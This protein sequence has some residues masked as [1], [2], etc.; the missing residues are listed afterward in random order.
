MT[1][2]SGARHRM[3]TLSVD[4]RA[5]RGCSADRA[6]WRS[7]LLRREPTSHTE[8]LLSVVVACMVTILSM[9]VSTAWSD[10]RIKDITT[11]AGHRTNQLVGLGLVT[12]LNGTGGKSPITRRFAM[13]LE[14]RLGVR[15]DPQVRS[16]LDNDTTRKTDNVS[17]VVVTAD[18][19]TFAR[20]GSKID[21]L[22]SAYDDASSLQGGVLIR[23]PLTA[24][25]GE[26]YAVAAGPVSI[27]GFSF[28]GQAASI[29]KNHPTTGRIPSGGIVE[30]ET[31]TDIAADGRFQLLLQTQDFETSRRIATAINRPFPASARALDPGTVDVVVPGQF[32]GNV[33]NFLGEIG[34][35]RVTPDVPARVV[36]N[37][38]TGTVIVGENVRLSRVL[39]THSNLT[40]TT[41]E[42]PEVSQPAPFSDGVTAIVPRTDVG[43]TE[44]GMPVSEVD[45]NVTVGDL[46]SAL[47]ALGV[48][49]R[50]LSSI[51]QQLKE[52]GALHAELE[53]K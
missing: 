2:R 29:S 7:G 13:N 52:S 1:F 20:S 42:S 9:G 12:G 22:V 4:R 10:V 32:L 21:V 25:D 38:R 53:F 45:P 5:A 49:P 14:Q 16:G 47:N 51:F 31:C 35:L 19:P 3:Q 6:R 50:D 28:G 48:S 27:G 33:P 46:A 18:L 26:A 39:I 17:V 44:D 30:R 15:S 34:N 23:T 11:V 36:I 40:V 37:E 8:K 43:V 24:V 41:A